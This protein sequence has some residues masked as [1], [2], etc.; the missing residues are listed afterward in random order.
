MVHQD[1]NMEVTEGDTRYL[2]RELLEGNRSHLR[3]GDV[4]A[5]GASI[6]ELELGKTL[7]SCGDAWQQIR[8]GDL[9]MFRYVVYGS[10][11]G[12]LRRILAD[13]D[14]IP[15]PYSISLRI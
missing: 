3:A 12:S 9:V 7:P 14:T 13:V 2:S 6:Y 4:F 10:Q 8:D 11:F 5:L 15:T 1:G